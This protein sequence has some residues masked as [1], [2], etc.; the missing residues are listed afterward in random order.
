MPNTL[1]LQSR[2]SEPEK[3][4]G[5]QTFHQRSAGPPHVPVLVYKGQRRSLILSGLQ[6]RKQ[7]V[8]F[9]LENPFTGRV[10]LDTTLLIFS[11]VFQHEVPAC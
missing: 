7:H 4:F 1:V 9:S 5:K 3:S 10:C 6:S 2:I 8:V 11:L